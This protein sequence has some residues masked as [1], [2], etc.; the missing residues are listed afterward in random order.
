MG[1][2]FGVPCE[3]RGF[4]FG[5]W[6]FCPP[7]AAAAAGA[8]RTHRQQHVRISG[9]QW[10]PSPRHPEAGEEGWA[11]AAAGG[12]SA[13]PIFQLLERVRWL[14]VD[15]EVRK[16][17]AFAHIYTY[18]SFSSSLTHNPTNQSNAKQDDALQE[19]FTAACAASPSPASVSSAVATPSP[20]AS[21][22]FASGPRG[23]LTSAG[24][25]RPGGGGLL[26]TSGARAGMGGGTR[27]LLLGQS[28]S[29]SPPEG[30]LKA[31]PTGRLSSQISSSIGTVGRSRSHTV[32]EECQSP[33]TGAGQRR[34]G[35][36]AGKQV[37]VE[38]GVLSK[39]METI[40]SLEARL[41]E[42]ECRDAEEGTK[43]KGGKR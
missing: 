41:R 23:S 10:R 24:A 40:D 4:Q 14:K 20:P 28:T 26:L 43:K 18:N 30:K 12:E 34:S 36:V 42:F 2:G 8:A 27:S 16:Q 25:H 11:A 7:D 35:G 17:T 15:L 38:E 13:W 6:E 1:Y 21:P 37:M 9:G 3:G 29:F 32:E 5:V 39:L 33:V 19:M 31:T 22:R